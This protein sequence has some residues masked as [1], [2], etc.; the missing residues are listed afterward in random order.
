M[1]TAQHPALRPA[2]LWP[3]QTKGVKTEL[4]SPPTYISYLHPDPKQPRTVLSQPTPAWSN[5]TGNQ[6]ASLSLQSLI[7]GSPHSLSL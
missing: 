3:P 2:S 6:P 7:P 1:P 5:L 4:S